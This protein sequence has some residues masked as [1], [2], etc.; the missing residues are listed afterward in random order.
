MSNAVTATLLELLSKLFGGDEELRNEF[1]D[2]PDKF[3]E[4][5]EL[6]DLSCH[7]FNDAVLAFVDTTVEGSDYNLGGKF[8]ADR[9]EH[10]GDDHEA[11]KTVIKKIVEEGDTY[12]VTNNNYDNDTVYDNSFKG[13]VFADGDV[14]F[15]NDITSA[16]GDGAVAAGDDINGQVVTG[17]E[18]FNDGTIVKGDQVADHGGAIAGGQNSDADGSFT[19]NDQ[20]NDTVTFT[21][22]SEEVDVDVEDAFNDN[23]DHSRDLSDHSDN[24]VDQ[25]IRVEDNDHSNVDTDAL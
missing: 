7:D 16:S 24:S 15:D 21:D 25:H 1:I 12:H 23:S 9:D 18:N 10:H 11:V 14:T 22:N 6:D 13:N 8:Y 17:D 3:I 4:K 2:N 5:Y 20:D 19:D